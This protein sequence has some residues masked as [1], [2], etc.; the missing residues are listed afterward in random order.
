MKL[1]RFFL[2]SSLMFLTAGFGSSVFAEDD[3]TGLGYGPKGNLNRKAEGKRMNAIHEKLGLNDEQKTKVEKLNDDH[4]KKVGE[5]RKDLKA[6]TDGLKAELEKEKTN[7]SAIKKLSKRIK[8]A[9]SKMVDLRTD[10]I[11]NLK[12]I[13][14]PEQFKK[15][16]ELQNDRGR[17]MSSPRGKRP[18]KGDKPRMK[19]GSGPMV[20]KVK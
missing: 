3:V 5:L 20:K 10:H 9:Q 16:N 4:F 14:S 18:K 13:L 6:A 11:L 2:I 15:L 19:D 17:R 1:K 12:G 8:N 7:K